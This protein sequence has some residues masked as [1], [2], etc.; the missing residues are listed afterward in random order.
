[1]LEN[2]N[3]MCSR[4]WDWAYVQNKTSTTNNNY[5]T[6]VSTLLAAKMAGTKVKIHSTHDSSSSQ[7]CKI[8]YVMLIK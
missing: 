7:Y 6:L 3:S 5:D 8:G 2:T 4:G 1:M